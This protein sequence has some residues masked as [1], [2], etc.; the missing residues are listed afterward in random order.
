MLVSWCHGGVWTVKDIMQVHNTAP[1][2]SR[3]ISKQH[4]SYKLCLYN[5]FCEKRLAKRHP[6]TIVG[7]S[8]G[9]HLLDVV[10][11]KWLFMENSLDKGSTD[12]FSSCNSL[13]IGSGIFSHSSQYANFSKTRPYLG[14][15]WLLDIRRLGFFCSFEYYTPLRPV[16]SRIHSQVP[17]TWDYHICWVV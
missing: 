14:R 5:A 10:W 2:E 13:H 11:V 7:R 1:C 9:L 12:T 3:L 4:V 17:A 15:H 16:T 6:C 8:E